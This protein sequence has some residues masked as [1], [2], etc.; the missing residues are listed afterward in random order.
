MKDMLLVYIILC[1]DFIGSN[2]SDGD[3]SMMAKYCATECKKCK[4][5]LKPLKC[6]QVL[7]RDYLKN[8]YINI[9]E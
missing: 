1:N 5:K 3:R 8:G 7:V 9:R 2:T 6:Y 4:L